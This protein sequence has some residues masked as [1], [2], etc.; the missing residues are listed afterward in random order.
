MSTLR[1]KLTKLAFDVPETRAALLPLLKQANRPEYPRVKDVKVTFQTHDEWDGENK[2]IVNF[3]L[4]ADPEW[5]SLPRRGLL[6]KF[7]EGVRTLMNWHLEEL[8]HLAAKK[9]PRNAPPLPEHLQEDGWSWPDL[10]NFKERDFEDHSFLTK[11]HL[12]G[13]I[14]YY[15]IGVGLTPPPGFRW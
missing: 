10:R 5:L 13:N 14:F 9:M 3:A 1:D 11:P 8:V 6:L 4:E 15:K 12:R 2:V 7:L